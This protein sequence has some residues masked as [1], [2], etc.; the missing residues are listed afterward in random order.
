[1]YIYLS[2]RT[3]K[4]LLS[5]FYLLPSIRI[6]FI[7]KKHDKLAA[8]SPACPR[9]AA[10]SHLEAS[11]HDLREHLGSREDEGFSD[12]LARA[13][14]RRLPD[15]QPRR[16]RAAY[17]RRRYS[18][19]SHEMSANSVLAGVYVPSAI[20]RVRVRVSGICHWEAVARAGQTSALAM[21]QP[22]G[23]A[24][25]SSCAGRAAMDVAPRRG[26][27]GCSKYRKRREQQS[28]WH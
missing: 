1:M 12:R 11:T 18:P 22:S 14:G 19:H 20:A 5:V 13:G 7:S 21:R 17:S 23:G 25:Q 2:S 26:W 9:V 6:E 8:P 15:P 24:K 3:R 4:L 28:E 10:S 16:S 27:R